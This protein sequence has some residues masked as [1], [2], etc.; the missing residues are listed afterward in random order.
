[1]RK[2]AALVSAAALVLTGAS[3]AADP[4]HE[5]PKITTVEFLLPPVKAGIDETMKVVA[6]DPDSWISEVQVRWEDDAHNGGVVF[7]HTGCVQD[8]D[9]STPGT[10]AKLLIPVNFDHPGTYH[11]EVRAIS[12]FKCRG[13]E[14]SKTSRTVEREVVVVDVF[15]SRSDADD[16]SGAFDIESIEQTQQSSTTS[17]TTEI[18]HRITTFEPWSND[19]LAGPAYMEMSFDLDG[20]LSS[21]ERVLTI[22]MD[23]NDGTL[24]ASMLDAATGQSRGYAAVGRPDDKTIEVR[25]PPLL[26][27]KGLRSYRWFAYVDSGAVEL[28]APTDPCT[29]RA[30]DAGVMRHRL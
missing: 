17:A 25:F 4:G 26:L 11:L 21:F 1:M 3:A 24:W 12:S 20:D 10:R 9:Y 18:I 2:A 19:A 8:P 13:G 5:R 15:S 29:D 6:H 7:A 27:R 23:E 16:A 22:D 14:D 28:C 30:P